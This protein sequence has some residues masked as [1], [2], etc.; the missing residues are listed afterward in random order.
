MTKNNPVVIQSTPVV[1][2]GTQ[3]LQKVIAAE[4]LYPE[5]E[6]KLEDLLED[7]RT[8]NIRNNNEGGQEVSP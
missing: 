4:V 2:K 1:A 5:T 8:T 6:E 7:G 3:E